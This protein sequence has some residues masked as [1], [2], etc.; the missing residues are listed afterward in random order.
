MI[1]AS[2]E[3][4]PL[5]VAIFFSSAWK[6]PSGPPKASISS[7]RVLS[8]KNGKQENHIQYKVGKTWALYQ[9]YAD[10]GYTHYNVYRRGK[11]APS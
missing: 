2:S 10:E 4:I 1:L 5:K 9:D 8:L 11:K 6:T 7:L 3:L